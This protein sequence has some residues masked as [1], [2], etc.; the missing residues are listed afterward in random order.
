MTTATLVTHGQTAD[1]ETARPRR[2]LEEL[3]DRLI[4]T[5]FPTQ[6]ETVEPSVT[7][8]IHE[9]RRLRQAGNIDGGLAT[10]AFVDVAKATPREARWAF[11]EWRDLVRRRFGGLDA[12]VYTQGEGRAAVLVPRRDGLL[13]VAAVLGMRWPPGKLVSGRSLRGLRPLERA[14]R[15]PV[16]AVGLV[17]PS[18][19][20]HRPLALKDLLTAGA[21]A[22]LARTGIQFCSLLAELAPRLGPYHPE[23]AP[24]PIKG[25]PWPD[26]R[27]SLPLA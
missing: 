16:S 26:S 14:C 2:G 9:A 25:G 4:E 12:L 24:T 6:T 1:T 15:G 7:R 5:L 21:W 17:R 27:R 8:S 18:P 19:R 10:L 3:V 13:E 11:S 23:P 20:F 22:V